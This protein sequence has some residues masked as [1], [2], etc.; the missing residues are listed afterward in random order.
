MSF[1]LCTV[2]RFRNAQKSNLNTC[3]LRGFLSPTIHIL[4]EL[5]NDYWQKF[6]L[7]ESY[8][9]CISHHNSIQNFQCHTISS[10]DNGSHKNIW[11]KPPF[12][13]HNMYSSLLL[14]IPTFWQWQQVFDKTFN[15]TEFKYIMLYD[16]FSIQFV[17]LSMYSNDSSGPSTSRG[18]KSG[19]FSTFQGALSL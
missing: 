6:T 4:T 9:L 15:Y 3:W 12:P 5:T 17:H 19:W 2:V 16:R 13:H 7:A 10:S 1:H 14:L 11:K 18:D 8:R